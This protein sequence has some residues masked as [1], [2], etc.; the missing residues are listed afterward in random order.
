MKACG[1]IPV[2][3]GSAEDLGS[4]AGYKLTGGALCL[5]QRKDLPAPD[6]VLKDAERIV[7]LES[8]N[9]P[10]NVGAIFRSAAALG[11]DALLLT[12][13]CS[14][15]LYRRAARVS[16]GSVFSLPWT[17]YGNNSCADVDILKEKGYTTL[18]MALDDDAVSLDTI[19]AAERRRV[20]VFLGNENNGLSAETVSSCDHT[21][22]I[23]MQ[24]GIDS[25]NV[26]AASA[27]AFWELFGRS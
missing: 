3:V 20:A 1:D 10:T 18:A 14:D 21:V 11:A 22:I 7:V 16:M 4:I 9:N 2:Y 12:P 25:L 15:P 24:R 8:I 23:P 19:P 17:Y 5:M 6:D 27:V 13:D 26:A